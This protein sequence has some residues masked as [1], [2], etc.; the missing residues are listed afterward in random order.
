MVDMVQSRYFIATGVNATSWIP[1]EAHGTRLQLGETLPDLVFQFSWKGRE[2]FELVYRG[3][4]L[5]GLAVSKQSEHREGWQLTSSGG[6]LE[7]RSSSKSNGQLALR[8][9][10]E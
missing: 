5:R 4:F 3:N 7:M 1:D 9:C 2:Q 8:W 10:R 6:S